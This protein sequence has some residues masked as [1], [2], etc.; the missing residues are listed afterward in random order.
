MNQPPKPLPA[1]SRCTAVEHVRS[2]TQS[3]SADHDDLLGNPLRGLYDTV[4]GLVGVTYDRS[5]TM[6]PHVLSDDIA[7]VESRIAEETFRRRLRRARFEHEAETLRGNTSSLL[8]EPQTLMVETRRDVHAIWRIPLADPA[9]ATLVSISVVDPQ[10]LP[11]RPKLDA[12]LVRA[13]LRRLTV[14]GTP[15][16]VLSALGALPGAAVGLLVGDLA[17]AGAVAGSGAAVGSML[18]A[19]VGRRRTALLEDRP[20]AERVARHVL[21]THAIG[22][23][24]L[25][26]EDPDPEL[27]S[28]VHA[29]R[30]LLWAL[31]DVVDAE[32]RPP[33][34]GPYPDEVLASIASASTELRD[35][36]ER[37]A[38]RHPVRALAATGRHAVPSGNSVEDLRARA[39]SARHLHAAEAALELAAAATTDL[40]D[41]DESAATG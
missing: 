40:G 33:S 2:L 19:L 30:A 39:R 9:Q 8:H 35:G 37:Y 25:P 4:A 1:A 29:A 26:G 36:L 6:S 27:F 20:S 13:S 11:R 5:V 32:D 12:F 21:H 10:H 15:I 23:D 7:P 41:A 16:P 17:T 38:E 31:V 28:A 14:G 24:L 34:D 22:V 18:P 3:T